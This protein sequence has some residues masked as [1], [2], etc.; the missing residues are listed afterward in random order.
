M[1]FTTIKGKLTLLL[2]ALVLGFGAVGF[3][4]VKAINDGKMAAVRLSG[5]GDVDAGL[6]ACMMELRGFQLLCNPKRLESFEVQ[7][8]KAVK[9]IEILN[10]ILT[11]KA[12]QERIVKLQKD[13][14][15]WY[16]LNLPRVEMLKK[17]GTEVN[18]PS[19]A[20]DHKADYELLGSLTQKSASLFDDILKQVDALDENVKK[21][22]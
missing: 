21:K 20:F 12:N 5:I 10:A 1:A 15:A 7:Y 11:S 2:L 14:L 22:T 4:V 6:S 13:V 9:H 8:K 3:Q 19:F 17:Y 18:T 16:Q